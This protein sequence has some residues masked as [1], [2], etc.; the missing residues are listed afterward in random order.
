MIG[1]PEREGEFN[2]ANVIEF[3][4]EFKIPILV[5]TFLAGLLAV[6]FSGPYFIHPKYKSSVILYPTRTNSIARALLSTTADQLDLLA[7]GTE[8]EAEQLLQVLE[9]DQI[10]N[11]IAQKYNLMQHYRIDPKSDYPHTYL[12]YKY[13]ENVNYHR[14]EYMSVEITVMDESRDTAAL[15]ANDIATYLDTV[16]TKLQQGRAAEALAIVQTRFKQKETMINKIT[17]SLRKL[18][19]LGVLNYEEQP[20]VL[21]EQY[22]R[23]LM[24][25]NTKVALELKEQE[26]L[27]AKYGPTHKKL[28]DMS[29]SEVNQLTDIEAKMNQAQ[30]DAE[31]NL[32]HKFVISGAVP[33]EKKAYPLRSLIVGLCMLSAFA[34][35]ILV[36]ALISNYKNLT[37]RKKISGPE[38]KY[39][40]QV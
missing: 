14:T 36:C 20:A 27:L 32:P 28:M 29:K 15:I 33:A 7:F 3:L 23:A 18:G 37:S 38:D 21:T 19:E 6:I 40:A 17:D 13:H 26:K 9:S 11:H 5:T 2:F 10:T 4:V 25:G 22:A 39:L 12:D 34:C 1:N 16:K 8:N 30:V 31:Q 35:S 24:S